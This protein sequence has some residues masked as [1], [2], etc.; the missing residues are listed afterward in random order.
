LETPTLEWQFRAWEREPKRRLVAIVAMALA[1]LGGLYL[2][3]HVL[4][5]LIGVVVIFVS[6]AEL[7]LPIKFRLDA[8]EARQS[9]GISVTAIRWADVKRLTEQTDGVRLSPFEKSHRL[10]AFRGVFLR[11]AS[12]ESEV[13]GTIA[14]LWKTDASTLDGRTDDGGGDR[15]R[16]EGRTGDPQ[17]GTGD[18][19]DPVL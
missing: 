6:T 11:Y 16:R 5:A 19:G 12:N 3:N 17:T 9:C 14:E 7:F 18:P 8:N 1:G 4:F 15:A 2:L 13:L 10:D